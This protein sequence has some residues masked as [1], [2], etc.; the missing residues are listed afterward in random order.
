MTDEM[1]RELAK[2]IASSATALIRAMGMVETN[3]QCYRNERIPVYTERD[4]EKVI[5][6]EGI[7]SDT[8][9]KALYW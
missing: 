7:Y 1:A 3:R 4:F 8:V 5:E 6:D 2:I 9:I